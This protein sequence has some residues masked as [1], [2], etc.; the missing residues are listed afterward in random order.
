M[1]A[2]GAKMIVAIQRGQ[3]IEKMPKH[4]HNYILVRKTTATIN[5]RTVVY[6]FY[7]C[8]NRGCPQPS[9]MEIQ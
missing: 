1:L 7:E 3:R 4:S 5:G 9:K 6:L 8:A 2:H